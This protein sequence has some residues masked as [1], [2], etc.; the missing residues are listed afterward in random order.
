MLIEYGQNCD[1]L[2]GVLPCA[3]ES[4][5]EGNFQK[6]VHQ[7]G[8]KGSEGYDRDEPPLNDHGTSGMFCKGNRPVGD[9]R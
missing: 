1:Y 6:P 7:A 2:S 9:M 4:F 3:V 5:H 8:K